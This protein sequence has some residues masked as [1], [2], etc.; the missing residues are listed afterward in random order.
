[1]VGAVSNT[2]LPDPVTSVIAVPLIEKL[3]PVPAVSNVLFVRV[4]VVSLPTSVSVDV[5]SVTVLAPP[6][7]LID[8]IIGVVKVLL[9]KVSVVFLPT[10]VSVPVGIVIV[11]EL[12]ILDI[13]G[14]VRVLLVK[15]SMVALPTNVSVEVGRV[16]VAEPLL[17]LIDAIIGVVIVGVLFRTTLPDPVTSVIAL[18]LIEKLLPVPAVS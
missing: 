13:T 18:P 14:V 1:M 7:V 16:N 6:L 8:A 11:P 2:T 4:S 12:E 17:V 9:V 3:L 15:V 5:G 10:S